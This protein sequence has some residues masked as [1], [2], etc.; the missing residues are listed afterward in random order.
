MRCI[1]MLEDF[2]TNLSSDRIKH[3]SGKIWEMR[4]DRY[5]LLYFPY[6]RQQFIMLRAFL[7][8]TDRTPQREIKIAIK[9]MADYT[10]T[11]GGEKK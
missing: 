6:G 4:V 2:G 9:R 7:K 10:H 1:Q 5:R 11:G 3:V 8:K